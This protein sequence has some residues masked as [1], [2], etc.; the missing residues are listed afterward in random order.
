M[1][2]EIIECEQQSDDW[3]IAKRGV[4]S[5]SNFSD[6]MAGG[7]GKTR[8][9][10]LKRLAAEV[11]WG[12]RREEYRN[13]AMDRGNR[14]EPQLR[15]TYALVKN[16]EPKQVGFVKRTLKVGFAGYSPDAFVGEDGLLECKSVAGDLMIDLMEENRVPPEHMKQLQGGLWVSGR[17]WID[18]VVGPETD[19]AFA[20]AEPFIR[21]VGRDEAAIARIALAV[22]VFNADLNLM[23]EWVRR[24][25]KK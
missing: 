18:I 23:V 6:V 4:P 9:R 19:P 1:T 14:M 24:W 25:G 5:A 3:W 11:V 7:E 22:E 20:G 10:Y 15:A 2:V 12:M 16:V 8:T 17:K 13:A 21:R